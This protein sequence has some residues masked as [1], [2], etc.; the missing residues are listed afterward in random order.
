MGG[1]RDSI[2]PQRAIAVESRFPA[3][4][5]DIQC[6]IPDYYSNVSL[7]RQSHPFRI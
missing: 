7:R 2:A 3:C 5:F 1:G 6:N 4:R